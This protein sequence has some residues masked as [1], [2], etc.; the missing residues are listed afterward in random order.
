[1]TLLRRGLLSAWIRGWCEVGIRLA[2][3]HHRCTVAIADTGQDVTRYQIVRHADGIAEV[4]GV[5]LLRQ[6]IEGQIH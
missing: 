4:G 5:I 2:V 3:S 1:M 6:L